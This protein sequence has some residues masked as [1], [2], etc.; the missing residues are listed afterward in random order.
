MNKDRILEKIPNR[1]VVFEENRGFQPGMLVRARDDQEITLEFL[2]KYSESA[3]TERV[4]RKE[5]ERF[6]L[7]SRLTNRP[8]R[9]ILKDDL[10]SYISFC[11]TVE[12]SHPDLVGPSV[13]K[14][15]KQGE[16]NPKWRPFKEN[17]SDKGI[18]F[19]C[20]VL[21]TFFAFMCDA[22][23]LNG[24]AWKMLSARTKRPTPSVATQDRKLLTLA[25]SLPEET[26][27]LL[28]QE[29]DDFRFG[30][31]VE[32]RHASRSSFLIRFLL[33]TGARREETALAKMGD[34]FELR[35]GQHVWSVVGKGNK[36]GWVALGPKLIERFDSY[37][38]SLGFNATVPAPG[39]FP[40][41]GHIHEQVNL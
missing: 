11:R 3:Q 19:A 6:L 14:F 17:L 28:L 40:L 1:D 27:K 38:R 37:K 18:S 39:D 34:I 8:Y 15:N 23:Y 26:V 21:Q 16:L 5:V 20:T 30:G 7:W 35:P 41:F 36:Q 32:R 33:G 25:Q 29:I 13:S 31:P 12:Q 2:S 10:E 22:G 24:N 9:S 4:F